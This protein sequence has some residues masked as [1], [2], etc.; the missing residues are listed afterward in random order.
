[1]TLTDIIDHMTPSMYALCFTMQGRYS[2]QCHALLSASLGNKTERLSTLVTSRAETFIGKA[3]HF[4]L[5]RF[6]SLQCSPYRGGRGYLNAIHA[7]FLM[8]Q[9]SSSCLHFVIH[10]PCPV[11][12]RR[13]C[14]QAI[15]WRG[16][17]GCNATIDLYGVYKTWD[18][19][20]LQKR[21]TMFRYFISGT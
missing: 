13:P 14:M 5:C 21:R 10:N 2:C 1:M 11:R 6:N 4:P 18:G 16:R 8:L 19:E 20:K 3:L 7:I 9:A 12:F 15:W 17:V